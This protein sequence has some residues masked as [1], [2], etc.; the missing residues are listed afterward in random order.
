[1]VRDHLL[2]SNMIRDHLLCSDMIR[3][4]LLCSDMIRDR[5][6]CSDMIRDR[7]LCS[8]MIRDFFLCSDMIRDRS[9][10][11]DLKLP[12][13]VPRGHTPYLNER[14][15]AIQKKI[16]DIDADLPPDLMSPH[17]VLPPIQ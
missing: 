7:F 2:C 13:K 8:D 5:S 1:M 6:L 16:D 15:V 17:P 12:S 3:D 10:G 14:S 9:F 4:F 11:D